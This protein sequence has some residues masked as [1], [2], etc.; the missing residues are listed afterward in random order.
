MAELVVY[1]RRHEK[2]LAYHH[3]LTRRLKGSK[4]EEAS[5]NSGS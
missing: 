5:T 3:F 1:V 2:L 4:I